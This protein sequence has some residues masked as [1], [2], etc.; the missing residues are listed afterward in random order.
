MGRLQIQA[1]WRFVLA[2]TSRW[3]VEDRRVNA[4]GV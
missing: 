2:A 1:Q 4:C 3:S